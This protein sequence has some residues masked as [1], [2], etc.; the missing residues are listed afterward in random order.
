MSI[1]PFGIGRTY[2]ERSGDQA[3]DL[4]ALGR[5]R[6]ASLAGDVRELEFADTAEV[7]HQKHDTV[8]SIV[9]ERQERTLGVRSG[10]EELHELG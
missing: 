3:L 2:H 10:R 1:S 7:V 4:H 6:F 8:S 5:Q 9:L